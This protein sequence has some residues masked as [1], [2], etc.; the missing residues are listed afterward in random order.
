MP[1]P[2]ADRLAVALNRGLR[3]AG[4]FGTRTY[5]WERSRMRIEPDQQSLAAEASGRQVRLAAKFVLKVRSVAKSVA[6]GY[7]GYCT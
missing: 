2:S 7:H 3:H 6:A 5:Q 4:K 1:E